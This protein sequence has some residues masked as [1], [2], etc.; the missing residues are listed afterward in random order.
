MMHDSLAYA[1]ALMCLWAIISP[2]IPTC[3]LGTAGLCCVGVG[4]LLTLDT[5]MQPAIDLVLT[6]ALL[7]GLQVVWRAHKSRRN[8]HMRRMSDWAPAWQDGAPPREVDI[9]NQRHISG[10]RK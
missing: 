5:R 2:V 7:G 4:A 6:G 9:T 3:V 10:G 8:R 1:V